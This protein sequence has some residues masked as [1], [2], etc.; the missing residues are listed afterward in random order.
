MDT[1]FIHDSDC[2]VPIIIECRRPICASRF[3]TTT[4]RHECYEKPPETISEQWT[5]SRATDRHPVTSCHA[6]TPRAVTLGR[7]G[8]GRVSHRQGRKSSLVRIESDWAVVYCTL[9]LVTG[10]SRTARRRWTAAMSLPAGQVSHWRTPASTREIGVRNTHAQVDTTSA[11]SCASA[12]VS[13]AVAL[14]AYTRTTFSVPEGL[15]NNDRYGVMV[16]V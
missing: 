3:R 2:S 10:W 16:V 15:H 14:S 6:T 8:G 12:L 4:A 13:S 11:I 5:E 9:L 7:A 1:Y